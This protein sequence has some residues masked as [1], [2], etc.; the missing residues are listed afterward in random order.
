MHTNKN[1]DKHGFLHEKLSYELRGSIYDVRNNYGPGHKETVYVNLLLESLKAKK[2]TAEKEKSIQIYSKD[3]NKVVGTYRPD[4][5]VDNKILVEAKSS[6]F[7]SKTNEIQLY[8]YLRNSKFEV[9][10]LVNFS[11]PKLYIK[12]IIYTNNNKPFIVKH[13]DTHR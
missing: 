7:T 2:I 9:S 13:T 8:H 4:I 12:R 11:T 1:T 10:Y 6:R 3:S 5:L